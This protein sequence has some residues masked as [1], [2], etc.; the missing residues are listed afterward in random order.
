MSLGC[1]SDRLREQHT[2]PPTQPSE[3]PTRTFTVD[4]LARDLKVP[5]GIAVTPDARLLVTERHGR[6]IAIR[7]DGSRTVWAELDVYGEAEG[8]GPESGLLGIALDP[9]FERTGH[10]FV[11]ATHR[12]AHATRT[13]S[14]WERVRRRLTAATR[15]AQSLPFE[16]R[17]IR[18]TDRDGQGTDTVTIIASLPTNHYHAGGGLA[19]GPEGMLYLSQGDGLLPALAADTRTT[20]GKI[21]RY[22]PD[23]T[24]PPDNPVAESPVWASGLRNTQAF[25]WLRDGTLF[26]V[27]HGPSGME[28]EDGRTG[29]DELNLLTAGANY[30]WPTTIGWSVALEQRAPLW[31]WEAAIAPAGLAVVDDSHGFPPRSILV[32]GLRGHL[33]WLTVARDDDAWRVDGRRRLIDGTFGRI[34]AVVAGPDGAIYLTTSNR[35]VRGVPRPGDDLLLR[36]RVLD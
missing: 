3:L 15:P 5:W 2:L 6:I 31:V 10:V 26:G 16:N 9:D 4:T 18:F 33:E 35:D 1:G 22:A 28:Q 24:I 21:L 7:P 20:L 8:I 32:G 27:D 25:G 34:R 19:F 29:H 13:N 12:R 30:G 23:G 36:L 11:L 14:L 17:V